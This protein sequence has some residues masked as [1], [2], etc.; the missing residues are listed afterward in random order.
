MAKTNL[1]VDLDG[2][3]ALDDHRRPMIESHG[4]GAYFDLCHNDELN[5][6]VLMII[7]RFWMT[8]NVH[9]FTG[10]ADSTRA[11]TEE[12]LQAHFVPHS[13]L[14]MRPS[15]GVDMNS[16]SQA[17]LGCDKN[18]KGALLEK[19]DLTPDNVEFV[20][21]DRDDMVAWWRDRGFTCFQVRAQGQMYHTDREE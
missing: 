7:E 19:H 4:W 5:Q 6:P 12:W 16:G 2:T 15:A 1:I 13:S 3:L 9:I 18:W 10:R 14:E 11:A 17:A 21:D 20:L 8:H